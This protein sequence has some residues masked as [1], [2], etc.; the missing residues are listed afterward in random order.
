MFTAVPPIF[1]VAA[2]TSTTRN[3]TAEAEL[4]NHLTLYA[5]YMVNDDSY[6]KLGLV[7]VDLD[8]NESLATGS[9]YGNENIMG[10]VLGLGLKRD[11]GGPGKYVKMELVY[12]DYEDISLT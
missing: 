1:K 8:T 4:S 9:K 7:N 12:T 6:V 11:A 3:Q 2:S 10:Y 5:D